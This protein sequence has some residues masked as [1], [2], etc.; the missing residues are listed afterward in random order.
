MAARRRRKRCQGAQEDQAM[1]SAQWAGLNEQ[2]ALQQRN[3][4]AEANKK[5]R[6]RCQ[7]LLDGGWSAVDWG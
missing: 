5:A 7:A 6:Q 2:T 4:S 1:A 3:H